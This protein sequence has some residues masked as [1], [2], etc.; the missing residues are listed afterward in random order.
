MKR[1]GE[2]R[3]SQLSPTFRGK[4]GS[5]ASRRREQKG[6]LRLAIPE[7][8]SGLTLVIKKFRK[9]GALK[10]EKPISTLSLR[11]PGGGEGGFRCSRG[12]S[13]L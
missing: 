7:K 4:K 9:E 8:E 5:L 3:P 6:R 11:E 2:E 13:P 1:D 10:K 12:K